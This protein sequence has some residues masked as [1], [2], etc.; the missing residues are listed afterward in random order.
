[1]PDLQWSEN[2]Y[3]SIGGQ[4]LSAME[5]LDRV[6]Q[7][8]AN[9]LGAS[10]YRFPSLIATAD[11]EPV[12]YLRSFPQLATFA[13]P[14]QRDLDTLKTL[15]LNGG[16][17][18]DQLEPPSELLTPAACY[19]FYPRLRGKNLCQAEFLTTVCQ[20]HRCE[21]QYLP[22]QRQWCFQMRELV[23]VGD[24]EAIDTFI[25]DVQSKIDACINELNLSCVWQVANDP[26][27]DPGSDPK[28][29]AQLLEPSKLE[30][31]TG[32]GLAISSI[33]RH[34]GFFAE[35]YDI[36]IDGK[37]AHSACIAFGL[38]RWLYALLQ[39]HGEDVSKWPPL[40]ELA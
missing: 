14:A 4:L 13:S 20:C 30:L 39:A 29:L 23:C 26:F 31:C 10:E 3:A 18:C 32:D 11:L 1:M 24:A 38:E 28:A 15:A 19:H 2:G 33:N 17:S 35:C 27:F 37:I 25:A 40:E 8:W 22:L 6:F 5:C 7:T 9:E 21:D 34:R 12:Q 16:A 36:T